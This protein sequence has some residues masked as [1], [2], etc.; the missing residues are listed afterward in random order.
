MNWVSTFLDS[1]KQYVTSRKSKRHTYLNLWLERDK[2]G[3]SL[4][5]CYKY[6]YF[7][8]IYQYDV[9][10]LCN[11]EYLLLYADDTSITISDKSDIKLN[12]KCEDALEHL[13]NWVNSISLYFKQTQPSYA[14]F[15]HNRTRHP[16]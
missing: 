12:K 9:I 13:T 15:I 3:R 14:D 8:F 5:V 11:D 6:N 4:G 7:Y 1:R 2:H 10:S 16:T